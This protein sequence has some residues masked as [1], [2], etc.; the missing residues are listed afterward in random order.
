MNFLTNS[1]KKFTV[2]FTN[3]AYLHYVKNERKLFTVQVDGGFKIYDVKCPTG[4]NLTSSSSN[5]DGK[6][7]K[8][9]N[10]CVSCDINSMCLVC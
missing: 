9:P 4:S 10:L 8:C 6:C 7:M 2:P 1:V 3:I 5:S